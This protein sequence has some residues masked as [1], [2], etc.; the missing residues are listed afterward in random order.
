LC[1][2]FDPG[3]VAKAID[4]LPDTL[5]ADES[6]WTLLY[7]YDG[8]PAWIWPHGQIPPSNLTTSA[9]GN[10]RGG[11]GVSFGFDL[12]GALTVNAPDGA[13]PAQRSVPPTRYSDV[14]GQNAAVEAARDLIELP[15]KHA[16]LFIRIGAKP[17]GHGIILA[18]PPG[19]GKT[20]LAR[21]V[22]GECGAHIEIVNG[23]ALLS[24]WVGET[25]AAIRDVFERAQKFAPAVIL[26]DEIDSIAPSRSAESA[27]HHWSC[28]MAFAASPVAWSALWRGGVDRGRG[29]ALE[30]LD[31][32]F[33][34][35][36]HRGVHI[37]DVGWFQIAQ[38]DLAL[39][40]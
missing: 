16:D 8:K 36:H 13:Q 14:L 4:A 2:F 21:A 39:L 17:S 20:L 34:V 22:A 3:A 31:S 10:R 26:F 28:S 37:D 24:K 23:P 18:G 7:D 27:Q 30:M 6:N 29:G 33:G 1:P 5:A 15:L 19:T 11:V 32:A 25:E 35:V 12:N 9:D 40:T 38:K